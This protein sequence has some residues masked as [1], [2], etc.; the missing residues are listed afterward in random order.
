MARTCAHDWSADVFDM[1]KKRAISV[2]ATVPDGGLTRLLGLC[3][4]DPGIRVVTLTTEEEGIGLLFGLWLGGRRGALFM[5]S[6]GTGNCVN[7]TYGRL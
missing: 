3:E 7:G 4:A 2:V 1:L 5:Q 6:S